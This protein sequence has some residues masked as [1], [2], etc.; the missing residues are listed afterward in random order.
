[1]NGLHAAL[2]ELVTDVPQYGDLDRAIARA[3]QERRRRYGLVAGLAAAAA[4]IL[5]VV[6][7]LAV[8]RGEDAAPPPVAPTPAPTPSVQFQSPGREDHP[9]ALYDAGGAL[10]MATM[11]QEERT[12]SATLWR[13]ESGRWQKLGMLQHAVPMHWK[14]DSERIRLS[15]G[16]GQGDII[17]VGYSDLASQRVGF[18]SDG[19]R[20]WSYLATC[21][22]CWIQAH[23]DYVYAVGRELTT[24]VR[25]AFGAGD[26]E[27]L[28]LPTAPDP[29]TGYRGPLVLD[30]GT[31]IIV[32]ET[33]PDDCGTSGHYRISRDHGDTWSK[34]RVTP[35][36]A[37]CI[38]GPTGNT[39]YA[40]GDLGQ[41]R[42]TDLVHWK[43]IVV[44]GSF[45]PRP[46]RDLPASCWRDDPGYEWLSEPPLR[47][48]GEVYRLFHV[49]DR[50]RWNGVTHLLK[51]SRDDCRT[52]Q[53]ALR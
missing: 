31:L 29:D 26:W 4:V 8:T 49:P 18:S 52:W 32:E 1:M 12:G 11:D 24:L 21:G 46:R 13:R 16:P 37:T 45:P 42:S 41:F 53:K 22:D 2:D 14:A 35:G 39:L 48:G 28:P 27:E 34:R 10:V 40:S 38:N 5:V 30:D 19:G 25:A 50:D 36:K 44:D 23:G 33:H 17:A 9:A 51:V 20:T 43:P 6:V 15:P 3:D 47:V 7:L